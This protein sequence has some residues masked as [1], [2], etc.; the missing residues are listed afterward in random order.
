M[1]DKCGD[2]QTKGHLVREKQAERRKKR[3]ETERDDDDDEKLNIGEKVI[4]F[5]LLIRE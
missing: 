2:K 4:Q 5:F 3:R 1:K